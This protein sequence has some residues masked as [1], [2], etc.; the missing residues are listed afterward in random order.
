MPHSWMVW[1]CG[2]WG[3]VWSVTAFFLYGWDK[4]Q[5]IRHQRRVR[6]SVLLTVSGLGGAAGA[7]LGM[8]L[9]RHKTRHWN[10]ILLN[11]LFLML[12]SIGLLWI[13]M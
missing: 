1:L 2:G 4:R 5:A 13:L 7:L 6:E 12:Q 9:F 3:L 8:Y 11:P 10:F